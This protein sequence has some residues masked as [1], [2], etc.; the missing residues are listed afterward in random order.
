MNRAVSTEA[1]TVSALVAFRHLPYFCDG[2]CTFDKTGSD[3]T[4][5][6]R[7]VVLAA[8]ITNKSVGVGFAGG[9]VGEAS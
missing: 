1:A 3:V 7:V 2:P 9:G 4:K 5:D 6:Q 8:L